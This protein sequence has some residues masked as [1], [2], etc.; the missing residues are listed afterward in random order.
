MAVVIEKRKDGSKSVKLMF[1]DKD[2]KPLYET[3]TKQCFAEEC[4][5]NNIVNR[6][7]RTGV[8][9]PPPPDTLKYGDIS[10]LTNLQDAMIRA[11][12][13]EDMFMRIPA[14]IRARFE[15]DVFQFLEFA[16]N[17]SN[18]DEMVKMGLIDPL[19]VKDEEST[20][21]KVDDVKVEVKESEQ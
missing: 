7:R 2:G 6:F 3:K 20:D 15:N 14:K 8:L 5:I 10:D 16:D 21:K 12:D 18:R 11:F 19:A 17:P 9:P 13:A 1:H 4:D